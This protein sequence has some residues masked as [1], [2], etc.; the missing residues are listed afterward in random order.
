MAK[1]HQRVFALFMAILFLATSVAFSLAVIWQMSK[2]KKSDQQPET[3]VTQ[4]EEGKLEGTKLEGFTPVVKVDKLEK[5]DI[6]VG[7]GEEVKSG[8]K[9]KAHYTGALASD[10]TIFQSSLDMGEPVDFSLD[11]VIKGWTEGVPG[12]KVGGT[13][14]LIIPADMAYGANPPQGSNIPPNAPLVFDITLVGVTQ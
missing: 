3:S 7:D 9:V 13:R 8:A 1:T 12:M 4:T 2:D 6:K 14:R 11:G 5:I 10:G